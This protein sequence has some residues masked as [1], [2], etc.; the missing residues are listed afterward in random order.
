MNKAEQ[1]AR[2]REILSSLD[3]E[4]F[5]LAN[6]K[7]T[8]SVINSSW[9]DKSE[10]IFVYVSVA[11]EPDTSKIIEA[12]LKSGKNVFVP[13]CISKSEMLAVLITSVRELSTGRFGIPEPKYSNIVAYPSQVDT[14]IVPCVCASSDGKRLGHG[15]G[16]YDRFLQDTQAIKICLCYDKLIF[17]DIETS[18]L[19]VTMDM[20]ITE[21]D[22]ESQVKVF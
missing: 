14:V 4:Y 10:N 12:A 15:A 3:E 7:I 19:D 13:R 2:A 6:S 18:S 21:K 22:E 9:F 17:S 8:A 11:N 20:V 16:Y 5:S 1:R